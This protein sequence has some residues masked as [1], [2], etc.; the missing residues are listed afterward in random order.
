MSNFIALLENFN[1]L[2]V[3]I[4]RSTKINKVLKAIMKLDSVPREE[5]FNFKK[6][7]Q[8]LLDK[9]N[10]LLATDGTPAAANGVNGAT[11]SHDGE[12]KTGTNGVKASGDAPKKS[13]KATKAASEDAET[14]D[15]VVETEA[16]NAEEADKEGEKA[17]DDAVSL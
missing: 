4:I 1:D 8:S 12:K 10:K 17:E 15:K 16:K 14:K 13:T 3:S 2:E 6:R 11:D 7:S 9:W 5:E